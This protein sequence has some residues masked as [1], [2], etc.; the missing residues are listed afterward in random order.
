MYVSDSQNERENWAE[1]RSEKRL[2]QG[3]KIDASW[4]GNGRG[5]KKETK[6]RITEKGD[7]SK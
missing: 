7:R 5:R 6:E 4:E 3:R 1:E 2:C